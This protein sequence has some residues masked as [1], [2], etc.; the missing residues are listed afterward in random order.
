MKLP[1]IM[2]NTN[3]QTCFVAF[4]YKAKN[5][6]EQQQNQPTARNKIT[7]LKGRRGVFFQRQKHLTKKVDLSYKKP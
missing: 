3:N 7:T 4:V 5:N 1:A 2:F 6:K